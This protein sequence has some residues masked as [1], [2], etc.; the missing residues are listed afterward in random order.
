MYD[1]ELWT[2]GA[3]RGN[4][5]I[6]AV[7]AWGWVMVMQDTKVREN[8]GMEKGLL[9]N[10]QNEI[11]AVIKAL[12]NI[13]PQKSVQNKLDINIYSDSAYV[14]NAI[15]KKWYLNWT[16]NNW[17]GSNNKPIANKELLI[18]LLDNINRLESLG[19]S[20]TFHKVKGHSDVKWNEYV[21]ALI[22][23]V[24]DKGIEDLMDYL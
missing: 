13:Q 4:G 6:D 2:D 16:K 10:N 12:E 14:V 15:N 3:S 1:I 8:A 22:N 17:R 21:D 11:F 5:E 19:S 23:S 9:T 18:R 24:M 7:T 20:I